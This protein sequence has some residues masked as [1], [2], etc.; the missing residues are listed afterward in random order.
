MAGT[1]QVG[2]E[3][4]E[5]DLHSLLALQQAEAVGLL[6]REDLQTLGIDGFRGQV[7]GNFEIA[8]LLVV[9]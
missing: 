9:R 7:V 8:Q 1:L 2:L 6:P 5:D 4:E 3:P